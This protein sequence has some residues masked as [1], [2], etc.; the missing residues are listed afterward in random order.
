MSKLLRLCVAADLSEGQNLTFPAPQAHYLTNVMRLG[1][2]DG[3]LLFNGREGEWRAELT[4][5]SRKSTV[6][7]ILEKTRAQSEEPWA[8]LWLLAAPLKKE[9]IDLVAE[10]AAELGAGLLWPV[11]TRRTV[12]NRAN[13]DRLA[14]RMLEAA[15]Q[16][17]RLSVP[18]VRASVKLEAALLDWPVERPLLLMDESRTGEPLLEVLGKLPRGGPLAVLVGPEGGFAPEEI[19]MLEALPFVRKVSLG[20]RVLRAETAALAALAGV[21]FWMDQGA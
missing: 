5:V 11:F 13:L 14:S 1:V 10:K 6:A 19:H 17:E 20:P 21:L 9:R 8:D 4:E 3:V 7:R 16:C 12:M 2:G 18:E 15:E